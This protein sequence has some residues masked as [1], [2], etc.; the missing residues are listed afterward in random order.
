MAMRRH[1]LPNCL[2]AA[3]LVGALASDFAS[4]AA[5]AST[6]PTPLL[7]TGRSPL[8]AQSTVLRTETGASLTRSSSTDAPTLGAAVTRVSAENE[9]SGS[10]TPTNGVAGL[11][12]WRESQSDSILP[13]RIAGDNRL[14]IQRFTDKPVV[15]QGKKQWL[16]TLHIK[17]GDGSNTLVNVHVTATNGITVSYDP[18]S[19]TVSGYGGPGTVTVTGEV[20]TLNGNVPFEVTIPVK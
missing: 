20:E 5:S 1:L 17:A 7:N 18:A 12:D 15:H 3:L 13:N 11:S 9:R 8:Q 10:T 6:V 2:A 19:Q 16:R 4:S 14:S